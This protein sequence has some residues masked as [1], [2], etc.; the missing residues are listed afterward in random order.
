MKSNLLRSG[1]VRHSL[2]PDSRN[3]PSKNNW[4][5]LAVES[6]TM[7]HDPATEHERH[8]SVDRQNEGIEDA[9]R[10]G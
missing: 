5:R 7:G 4:S 3:A 9:A 10:R 8:P 1:S 6:H 2:T